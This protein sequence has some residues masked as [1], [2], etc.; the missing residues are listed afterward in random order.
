MATSE[1]AEAKRRA[2][3]L[4]ESLRYHDQLY[5]AQD[6]PEISDAEYDRIRRSLIELEER[7]PELR[8]PDSPTQRIGSAAA[9]GFATA[10]HRSPMLSLDNAMDE[11]AMRAFDER[12]RRMLGLAP[13][14]PIGFVGEPKLDGS[15][16][17]L[18][19]A[20]GRFVQ[21]LTRGDGQVGEDVTTNLAAVPTIPPR[22]ATR[23][24]AAAIPEIASVR[25]EIVLPLAAFA[26]L[27]AARAARDEEPFANPRNAAAGS[28][29]QIHNGDQQRLGSLE[30]RAYALAEGAL[31]VVNKPFDFDKMLRIVAES[32][33]PHSAPEPR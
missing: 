19:Y 12:I 33:Q 3:Q 2:A 4:A 29:R 16:V 25:G 7:F 27:N 6:A 30:F 31:G 23:P 22:L 10:P 15:G 14:E 11:G 8:T 28:L 18:I 13:A 5:F 1:R 20:A 17:E 32:L 9:P 26:A 21:G 24:G